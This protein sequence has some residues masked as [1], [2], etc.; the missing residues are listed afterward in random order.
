MNIQVVDLFYYDVFK[1]YSAKYKIFRELYEKDII[2]LELRDISYSLAKKIKEIILSNKEICY[3]TA[4]SKDKNCDLLVMGSYSIFKELAKSIIAIGN[5]D[6]GFKITKTV[7][8]S[9]DYNSKQIII[10]KDVFALNRAYVMG[11]LN[12]TPDSFS[13][14]GNYFALNDAVKHGL[15]LLEEGAD[16]LDIGGESTRPDSER[17]SEEEE[18]KRV[19]PVLEEI[20]A[21]KPE[22][23]ISIDTSKA[24]VAFEALKRGAKLVNDISGFSFEEEILDAVKTHDA[25]YI[26]MHMK[27]TPKTMQDSP[28][29][30]DVVSEI[31]DFLLTK[32]E[33]IK[34][35]GINNIIID[36]GIG[37]GKRVVDNFE[38]IKRLN[39]FRG[40]G[41]PLLI[42][43]SKKSFIGKSLNLPLE[44]R[45]DPT[46]IAET[47]ALKNG[48]R[49]IRTHNVKKAKY[50][51]ELNRFF[52]NPE[53]LNNV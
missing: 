5:E 41:H 16:I 37:F 38:I 30:E 29:Y 23:V 24:K 19:I 34:K 8:N 20:L 26:L 7:V 11:V 14:G 36:P 45:E 32:S 28:D 4:T 52:E 35:Q 48:A 6:I 21:M 43:L 31:Y 42:G 3:S 22:A 39:E 10:G 12:V 47:V 46:L 27:G 25:A 33:H 49:F 15:M 1:R 53:M 44:E 18:L 13:D 17:V 2:G 51:V 9:T 50:A 40:I